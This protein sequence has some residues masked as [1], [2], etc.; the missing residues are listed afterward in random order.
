MTRILIKFQVAAAH[1][2]NRFALD[3][4]RRSGGVLPDR[5]R[6][7]GGARNVRREL[8]IESLDENGAEESEPDELGGGS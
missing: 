3:A 2:R 7:R 6:A 5:R 1:P 8:E 4:R